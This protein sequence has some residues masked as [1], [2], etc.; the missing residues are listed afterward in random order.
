M[1]KVVEL[2]KSEPVAT[3]RDGLSK[4]IGEARRARGNLL[5]MSETAAKAKGLRP[6]LR[7]R[8]IS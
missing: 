4:A 7:S 3:G 5:R 8:D 2:K 6:E 1:A